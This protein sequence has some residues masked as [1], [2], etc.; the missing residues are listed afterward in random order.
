MNVW[1]LQSHG[2]GRFH[3]PLHFGHFYITVVVCFIVFVIAYSSVSTPP[4]VQTRP[5]KLTPQ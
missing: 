2:S 1:V 4:T 5:I 3:C